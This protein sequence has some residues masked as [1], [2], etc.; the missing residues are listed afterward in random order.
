[1]C[2]IAFTLRRAAVG[3]SALADFLDRGGLD[4]TEWA[5]RWEK[6]CYIPT[7]NAEGNLQW[8]QHFRGERIESL[9][10]HPSI[11]KTFKLD[12]NFLDMQAA[13]VKKPLPPLMCTLWC[14]QPR[15][16]GLFAVPGLTPKNMKQIVAGAL[17]KYEENRAREAASASS[18]ATQ[19]L[20]DMKKEAS[21]ERAVAMR[22][23]A[24]EALKLKKA[25]RQITYE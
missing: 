8:L 11:N 16:S 4:R 23:K 3:E 22:A 9:E 2:K 12:T 19:A 24:D 18:G 21:K 13:W 1:M 7:W 5:L 10:A 14:S 25:R 20:T 15:K 6:G 17:Q